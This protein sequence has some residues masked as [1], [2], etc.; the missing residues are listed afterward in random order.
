MQQDRHGDVV[1]Q[2]GDQCRRRRA[3]ELVDLQ[4]V[5]EY[6]AHPVG[7]LRGVLGDRARQRPG[8]HGVDLD[9]GDRRRGLEQGQ[10]QRAQPG[11]DLDH[12]V[13]G[14]D[15]GLAD[16][17]ADR[18]GVDDEVLAAL[19]GRPQV[20]RV[21]RANALP[22]AREVSDRRRCSCREVSAVDHAR[23][24]IGRPRLAAQ[25]GQEP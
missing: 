8:Q 11:A 5:G 24:H 16:D 10:G 9:R 25:P 18:V 22:P 7:V 23:G 15:A 6:D 19:L 17:P 3:G 12:D 4:R 1:G 13:V 14:R 2:V 20:Q 21:L